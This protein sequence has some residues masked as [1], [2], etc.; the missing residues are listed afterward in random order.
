MRRFVTCCSRAA[1]C[2]SRS[3]LWR[4]LFV[5]LFKSK[6]HHICRKFIL[7]FLRAV[8]DCSLKLRRLVMPLWFQKLQS[9][10][11]SSVVTGEISWTCW[12]FTLKASVPVSV[13]R[14]SIFCSCNREAYRL[15]WRSTNPPRSELRYL[16]LDTD[17]D[18]SVVSFFCHWI[19]NISQAILLLGALAT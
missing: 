2:R 15:F 4:C 1:V 10:Y 18:S 8:W 7:W 17:T 13:L 12:P 3:A 9:L 14:D 6:V 11:V 19:T 5:I 16:Q